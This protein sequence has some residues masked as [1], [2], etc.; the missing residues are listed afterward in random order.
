[1][2]QAIPGVAAFHQVVFNELPMP[3]ASFW[4]QVNMSISWPRSRTPT[5]TWGQLRYPSIKVYS[6]IMDGKPSLSKH[7][8]DSALSRSS[9]NSSSLCFSRILFMNPFNQ[10]FV[11]TL[12]WF[13]QR[14]GRLCFGFLCPLVT[15][16]FL[17][18]LYFSG[19]DNAS[20]L[21]R[22]NWDSS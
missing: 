8:Y 9:R 20:L 3:S 7:F 22:R 14:S 10:L 4:F 6:P 19:W 18:F 21:A 17:C 12:A 13:L 2:G 1:M 11:W 16:L 15:L 5:Q